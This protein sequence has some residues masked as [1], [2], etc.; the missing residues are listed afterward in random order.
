MRLH[1]LQ[2]VPFEGLGAIETWAIDR[3]FDITCTKLYDGDSLPYET[4]MD[5]L[6]VMGGPMGVKD[7]ADYPW[8]TKEKQFLQKA[9][10]SS[11]KILGVCLGAQLLAE[12]L[13]ENVYPNKEKEIGWFPISPAQGA[14]HHPLGEIFGSAKEVFHWHG[15]TFDIPDT[16]IH[17][18]RS[19]VCE[20]QAFVLNDRIL[21]LQFHLETTAESAMALIENCGNELVEASFIQPKQEILKSQQRFDSINKLMEQCLDC[22]R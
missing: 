20:A 8:L 5:L 2:H 21:G 4:D 1:Y 19:E 3:G 18:A 16:A 13:G 22:F 11:T 15:D 17:L 6:V 7:V 14:E 9:V 12:V 10:V